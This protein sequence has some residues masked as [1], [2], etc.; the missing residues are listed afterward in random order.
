MIRSK[1][2]Q[3]L[4]ASTGKVDGRDGHIRSKGGLTGGDKRL[5]SVKLDGQSP[6]RQA[7]RDIHRASA[8]QGVRVGDG[9]G[10]GVVESIDIPRLDG[11]SGN[12]GDLRYGRDWRRD[13]HVEVHVRQV[14]EDRVPGVV[15]AREVELLA[16]ET[17]HVR[18]TLI[19][20]G[21][22]QS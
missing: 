3:L 17:G 15:F 12:V 21:G 11:D 2:D 16:A 7:T 5:L 9:D 4:P 1:S 20:R 10:N 22:R 8:F 14:R 6:V 13:T 19:A 18:V